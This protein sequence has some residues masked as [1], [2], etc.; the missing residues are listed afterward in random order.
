MQKVRLIFAVI[1]ALQ[2]RKL[3]IGFTDPRVVAGGNLVRTQAHR[4]I[5]KCSKL[6]LGVAQHVRVGRAPGLIF[7]QK[8]RK[9]AILVFSR[10]IDDLNVDTD[11]IG[12][13]HRVDQI[14][15]R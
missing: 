15:A 3:P 11:V 13:A 6:D 10:E 12:H 7:G 5:E 4:V 14:L 9:H 8:V 2:K 1:I